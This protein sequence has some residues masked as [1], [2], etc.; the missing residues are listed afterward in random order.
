MR[1]VSGQTR[2]GAKSGQPSQRV[3]ALAG[4]VRG[5]LGSDAGSRIPLGIW[6]ETTIG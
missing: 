1:W 5:A 4:A 6:S 2:L 3:R